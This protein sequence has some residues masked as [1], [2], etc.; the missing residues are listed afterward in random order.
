MF[1]TKLVLAAVVAGLS[2]MA[3]AA[4]TPTST[5]NTEFAFSAYVGDVGYTFDLADIGFNS[6][7]GSEVRMNSLIGSGNQ[8]SGNA[9][10]L[11]LTTVALTQS[12]SNGIVFDLALPGFGDFLTLAGG[13]TGV[14][15]SL[16][17]GES[18]GVRRIIQTVSTTPTNRL[19]TSGINTAVD[20]VGT[21]YAAN[22]AGGTHTGDFAVDGYR[23]TQRIDGLAFGGN[24]VPA[25]NGTYA[26][27]GGLDQTLDLYVVRGNTATPNAALGG[28]AQLVGADGGDVVAKVYLGDAG[29]YH[30]QI[31]VVPEPE[32]YA[33]LLA[34]LGMI[35]FA[36]RR[37][38]R[39]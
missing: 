27:V 9:A 34:G 31:A 15:W 18:S 16:F 35:G 11:A 3:N 30:L 5:G 4:I 10:Q 37:A 32:T 17:N 28:F 7:F 38:R 6:V 13:A 25:S 22:N 39:A 20:N 24:I 23:I 33:L 12:V 26:S 2:S 14:Q 8:T 19:A 36:A 1:K 29:Q 21:Y